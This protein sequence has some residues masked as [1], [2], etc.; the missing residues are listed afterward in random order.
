MCPRSCTPGCFACKGRCKRGAGVEGPFENSSRIPRGTCASRG[1]CTGWHVSALRLSVRTT[2]NGAWEAVLLKAAFAGLHDQRDR[3]KS[4]AVDDAHAGLA[5]HARC[6]PGRDNEQSLCTACAD[7]PL[8]LWRC[9]TQNQ[10]QR[11]RSRS[12]T[13][14]R[15][16]LSDNVLRFCGHGIEGRRVRTGSMRR[17]R[18]PCTCGPRS[19]TMAS[20]RAVVA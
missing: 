4:F 17:R 20:A 12:I 10:P 18:T 3:K 11:C 1:T 2:V 19:V 13:S 14:S 8:G 16:T 5:R 7:R 15:G 9:E 6:R